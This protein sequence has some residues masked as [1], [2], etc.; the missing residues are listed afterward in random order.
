MRLF[1]RFSRIMRQNERA[2]TVANRVI[3]SLVRL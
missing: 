2:R 1:R 3:A